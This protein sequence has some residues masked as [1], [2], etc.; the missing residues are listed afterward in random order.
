MDLIDGLRGLENGIRDASSEERRRLVTDSRGR[1]VLIW[2]SL[3]V[4]LE[5]NAPEYMALR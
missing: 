5:P 2:T 1:R 4:R 3:W